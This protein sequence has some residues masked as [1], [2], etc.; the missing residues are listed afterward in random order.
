MC[1]F[2][3]IC[4]HLLCFLGGFASICNQPVVQLPTLVQQ[5]DALQRCCALGQGLARQLIMVVGK[6]IEAITR[7]TTTS[8]PTFGPITQRAELRTQGG[9]RIEQRNSHSFPVSEVV[10]HT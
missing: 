10:L 9:N 5:L 6:L 1:A 3:R 8:F 7:I 2:D 4:F